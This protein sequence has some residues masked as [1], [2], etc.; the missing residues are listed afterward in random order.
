MEKNHTD[1][2]SI[3]ADN[4]SPNPESS[5]SSVKGLIESSGY[6]VSDSSPL[7]KGKFGEVWRASKDGQ[8]YAVKFVA[9]YDAEK[10]VVRYKFFVIS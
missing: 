4:N 7:G 5:I 9:G 3:N 1:Y 8:E 10:E 2:H 6:I